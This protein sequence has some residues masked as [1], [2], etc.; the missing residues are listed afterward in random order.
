MWARCNP[1][2]V[3]NIFGVDYGSQSQQFVGRNATTF[4]FIRNETLQFKQAQQ[5]SSTTQ[6][7][8]PCNPSLNHNKH[9]SV[10]GSKICRVY[11]GLFCI[12]TCEICRN[13]HVWTHCKHIC[14]HSFLLHNYHTANTGLVTFAI[15]RRKHSRILQYNN[16]VLFAESSC[17]I[18]LG[19]TVAGK[20][21][22]FYKL[23][24][25]FCCGFATDL[26]LPCY[27]VLSYI[28]N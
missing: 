28:G 20:W 18:Y 2:V 10:S 19:I 26:R 15:L 22:H 12:K 17:G 11:I 25:R 21:I 27:Q 13:L 1:T 24:C 23:Q 4:T 7:M 8:L 5:E 6:C 3:W 9:V 14:M 16:K